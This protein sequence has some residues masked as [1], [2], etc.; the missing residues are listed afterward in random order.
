M[1]RY[2]F[3]FQGD[4][5]ETAAAS[6]MG[7]SVVAQSFYSKY[8][9]LCG[10]S[11]IKIKC[12]ALNFLASR[13]DDAGDLEKMWIRT[14]IQDLAK[15]MRNIYPKH[16]NGQNSLE[17]TLLRQLNADWTAMSGE[18]SAARDKLVPVGASSQTQEPK[19]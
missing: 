4:P 19:T 12:D 10:S 16:A 7:N 6:F 8:D 3:K 9:Y 13:Y 11:P 15:Q 5:L 17:R 2:S 1:K 14:M 18:T